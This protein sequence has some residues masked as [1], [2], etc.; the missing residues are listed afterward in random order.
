MP[1]E[2]FTKVD[3]DTDLKAS[4]ER[5]TKLKDGRNETDIPL[6]DEYWKALKK[7]QQAYQRGTLK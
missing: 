6:S 3:L 4:V 2:P 1:D 5:L 7:H